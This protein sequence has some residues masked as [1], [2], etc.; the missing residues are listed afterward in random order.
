MGE[1]LLV[2]DGWD[3]NVAPRLGLSPLMATAAP[4]CGHSCN[5][6]TTTCPFSSSGDYELLSTPTDILVFTIILAGTA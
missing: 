1:L 2:P 4:Y 3:K 6:Y 5:S